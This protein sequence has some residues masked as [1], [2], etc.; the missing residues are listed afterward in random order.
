[1]LFE[2]WSLADFSD[3]E[4]CETFMGGVLSGANIH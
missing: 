4:S 2:P 1:M 3:K